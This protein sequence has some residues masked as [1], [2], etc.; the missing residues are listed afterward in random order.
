MLRAIIARHAV[1]GNDHVEIVEHGITRGRFDAAL[2]GTAAHDDRLD[3]IAPQQQLEVGTPEGT[4][5][6]LE[7]HQLTRTGCQLVHE[8]MTRRARHRVSQRRV[9]AALSGVHPEVEPDLRRRVAHPVRECG[10]LHVDDKHACVSRVLEEIRQGRPLRLV[11]GNV[12]THLREDPVLIDEVA[13]HVDEQQG[14]IRRIHQL[15]QLR[16]DLL[17]VDRDHAG[18]MGRR[19]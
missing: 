1:G 6:V 15:R 4:R 3:S 7:H 2:G 12:D 13:L 19:S 5:A 11:H 8:R 10:V 14:C 16:E 17:A 18:P 9:G